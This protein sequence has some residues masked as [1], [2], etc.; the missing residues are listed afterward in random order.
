MLKR[1]GNGFGVTFSFTFQMI[2]SG[3][4]LATK[5]TKTFPYFSHHTSPWHIHFCKA[6]ITSDLIYIRHAKE[7][8]SWLA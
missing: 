1:F 8:T 6:S 2:S 5:Q 4:S 7:S 3:D